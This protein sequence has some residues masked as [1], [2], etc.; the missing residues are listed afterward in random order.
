MKIHLIVDYSFL[1][2]KY[3]FQLESGRMARLTRAMEWKGAVIEKDI[4]QIYYSMREIE[5][6]RR[7]WEKNKE[8]EVVVSVCF[9]MPPKRKTLGTVEAAKYKSNRGSKLTTEDYENI[10][11]VEN[12]LE[13]AG[14]NTYRIDGYEADDIVSHI[15]KHYKDDFDYNVIYTPDA[16]LLV[17]V[18]DNVGAKRYKS[19]RG[20]DTVTKDNFNDYLSKEFKCY[21]PY[22][23][24]ILYKCTVG[25]K[26]D[27]IDGIKK[28]GPASFNKLVNHL[29]AIGVDWETMGN[30]E[31]VEEVLNRCSSYFKPDQLEQALASLTLVKAEDIPT[32]LV[33]IPNRVSDYSK[34]CAAYT[35]YGMRSL[36]D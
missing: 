15:I 10:A 23:A 2:Y 11:F 13:I 6:F 31:A 3:K 19:G 16:D 20:Y 1:Y 22:N 4:S 12:V 18:C 29:D 24:L 28:F 33:H 27:C 8:C 21:L 36:I 26:S 35:P 14:Y 32:E 5:M 30:C 34:R 9:D 25:D 7:S 17:N